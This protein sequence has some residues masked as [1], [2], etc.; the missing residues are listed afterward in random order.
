MNTSMNSATTKKNPEIFRFFDNWE[1]IY[2]S[3][4]ARQL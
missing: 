2:Y 4:G 3:P 1:L